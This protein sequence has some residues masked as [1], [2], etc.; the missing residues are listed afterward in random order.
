[1]AQA[2]YIVGLDHVVIDQIKATATGSDDCISR[3][4]ERKR[5]R[6]KSVETDGIVLESSKQRLQIVNLR[7]SARSSPNHCH[8][9]R[10]LRGRLILVRTQRYAYIRQYFISNQ[11]LTLAKKK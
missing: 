6:K 8:L 2:F 3:I 1:M 4:A 9:G 11:P 5:R 7:G 10:G